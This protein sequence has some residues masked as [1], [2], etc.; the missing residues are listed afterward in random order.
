MIGR[1]GVEHRSSWP[2]ASTCPNGSLVLT[3]RSQSRPIAA[4]PSAGDL[5]R[6][7]AWLVDFIRNPAAM[8][9]RDDPDAADMTA[10]VKAES[11]RLAP[12]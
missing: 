1:V 2:P 11:A 6:D 3:C 12:R 5:R 4:T 10:Y 9:A 8:P 7:R